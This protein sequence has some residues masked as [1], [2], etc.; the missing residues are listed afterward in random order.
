M[1]RHQSFGTGHGMIHRK[2]AIIGLSALG[3][4]LI[5]IAL[6]F[7][8][9]VWLTQ[10][11]AARESELYLAYEWLP[12]PTVVP[13]TPTTTV[14]PTPMPTSTPT[15]QPQPPTRLVIP[16]IKVNSA[17]RE[18]GVVLEADSPNPRAIWPELGKGVGHDRDSAN[19][20]EAGNIILLGHNNTAGEVF[21]HLNNLA[22]GDA[23]DLYTADRKFSYVVKRL[24]IVP[25]KAANAQDKEI[26]AFYLGPKSV[27]TLTLVSCWP[28]VTYTHRIYVVAEPTGISDH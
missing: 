11:L 18:I 7:A 3:T 8:M 17:V 23:I 4:G 2:V 15:P 22:P 19:P 16:R 24:D 5:L 25:A 14:T 10:E 21:R 12:E 27:E 26:H 1:G 20:G 6:F 28:Y 13:A 9:R